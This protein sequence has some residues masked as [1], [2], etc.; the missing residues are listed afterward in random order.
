M[1]DLICSGEF[2]T[3]PSSK[4]ANPHF[5]ATRILDQYIA[6]VWRGTVVSRTE[7]LIADVVL[8]DEVTKELFVHAG[9]VD[10]LDMI[11]VVASGHYK[12]L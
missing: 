2:V 4:A 8:S 1:Y 11:L 5:D 6:V 12:P 9:L 7:D 10:D 3:A